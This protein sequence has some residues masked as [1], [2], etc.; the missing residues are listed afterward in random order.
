MESYF[1]DL[2]MTLK[3]CL[4]C[5]KEFYVR[6]TVGVEP[7]SSCDNFLRILKYCL[8][9][10][11]TCLSPLKSKIFKSGPYYRALMAFNS[12]T[13]HTKQLTNFKRLLGKFPWSI[14]AKV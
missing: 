10:V 9:L 5:R 1:G 6:S 7:S 11:Y 14:H 12:L 3:V 4:F 13:R 8:P 2:R